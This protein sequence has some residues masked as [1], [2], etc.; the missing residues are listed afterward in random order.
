MSTNTEFAALQLQRQIANSL[1]RT[2]SESDGT[3]EVIMDLVLRSPLVR[4]SVRRW[5]LASLA[6]QEQSDN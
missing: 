3:A 5:Y 4:Q 2:D 1:D 6:E